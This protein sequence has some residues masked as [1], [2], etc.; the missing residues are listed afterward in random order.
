MNVDKYYILGNSPK[1]IAGNGNCLSEVLEIAKKEKV[2]FFWH[3]S[4]YISIKTILLL[5]KYSVLFLL[6]GSKLIILNNSK[7]ELY[8]CRLGLL[9]NSHLINQNIH[10][11][12]HE[13]QIVDTEKE[14]DAIYIAQARP[15]KRIELASK[16]DKLYVLTYR[17][18]PDYVTNGENDLSKLVPYLSSNTKWNKDFINGKEAIST[19]ISKSK[20]GL[21][22]SKK[23]G[24]MWASMQYLMCGVPIVSTV[25]KGGRDFFFDEDYVLITKDTI[26][27]IEKA[28][29]V[30]SS[31][32]LSSKQIR[33]MT[34]EKVNKERL[35][36]VKLIKKLSKDESKTVQQWLDFIYNHPKGIRQFLSTNNK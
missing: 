36:F 9:F 23:E 6:N 12:E 15:F 33:K 16:I 30:L 18:A 29:G 3:P 8:N 13:F 11:C 1:I 28:V 2:L 17:C 7:R 4:W 22:L 32:N 27:D 5:W 14:Y 21:A 24:A 34:L 35:K 25:S 10:E 20:V 26:D 31:K 19:L